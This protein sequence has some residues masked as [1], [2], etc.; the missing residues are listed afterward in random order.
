MLDFAGIDAN[1]VLY[2]SEL[3]GVAKDSTLFPL[4]RAFSI[5]FAGTVL[6]L[7]IK[8]TF[9]S[10]VRNVIVKKN[11]SFGSYLIKHKLFTNALKILP[12]AII[13][14][15]S[16]LIGNPIVSSFVVLMAELAMILIMAKLAISM[17]DAAIDIAQHRKSKG[18]R[19][20]VKSIIQALK[21]V[22]YIAC[23]LSVIAKLTDKDI[24]TFLSG[25]AGLLGLFMVLF[26]E[27]LLGM[28]AGFQISSNGIMEKGDWVALPDLKIDALVEDIS[29][30]TIT[31][32]N[33]NNTTTKMPASKVLDQKVINYNSMYGNGRRIKESLYIDLNTVRFLSDNEIENLSKLN[34]LRPYLSEKIAEINTRQK[35]LC[36]NDRFEQVNHRNLTNLGTFRAY[37]KAYLENHPQITKNQTLLVRKRPTE[38]SGVPLE[39]Y[40]FSSDTNWINYEEISSSIF[41]HL[42]SVIDLFG[43]KLFQ[44]PTGSDFSQLLIQQHA[45]TQQLMSAEKL[46]A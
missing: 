18:K 39:I 9:I 36:S 10:L 11:W 31:F 5:L 41:E 4:L 13:L 17:L 21:L 8:K 7:G 25:M 19:L 28:V 2:L 42:Y 23:T 24:S 12:V 33:W 29:L 37:V 38:G 3:L 30:T 22:I 27:T 46:S 16:E 20:P 45:E 14:Q 43:L 44:N 15:T 40:A 1:V 26:R 34:I 32:G 35:K 6:Y